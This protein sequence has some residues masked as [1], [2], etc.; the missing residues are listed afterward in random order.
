MPPQNMPPQMPNNPNDDEMKKRK[1]ESY[2]ERIDKKRRGLVTAGTIALLGGSAVHVLDPSDVVKEEKAIEENINKI[3]LLSSLT[4]EEI[5]E[6]SDSYKDGRIQAEKNLNNFKLGVAGTVGAGVAALAKNIYGKKS[7]V[8]GNLNNAAAGAIVGM[9]AALA[10]ETVAQSDIKKRRD[11]IL[12]IINKEM[13]KDLSQEV[14]K[15]IREC[16]INA[17]KRIAA[18]RAKIM[19]F[20]KTSK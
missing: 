20:Q 16:V 15:V 5:R 8:I 4:S 10:T 1:A 6:L 19:E 11:D 7:G 3:K 12:L 17:E 14:I 13:E 9:A 18:S 2:T